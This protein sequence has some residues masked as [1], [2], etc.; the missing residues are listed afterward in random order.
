MLPVSHAKMRE[1]VSLPI[2][3]QIK[4]PDQGITITTQPLN[5][6]S[7]MDLSIPYWEGPVRVQGSVTGRGFMEATGY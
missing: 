6:Q 3:W 2:A 5:R 7:W 4:V 1:G